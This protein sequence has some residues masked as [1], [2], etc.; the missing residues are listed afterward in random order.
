ME[1]RGKTRKQKTFHDSGRCENKSLC[2]FFFF[3][4]ARFANVDDRIWVIYKHNR[5]LFFEV[6]S[7]CALAPH[8]IIHILLRLAPRRKLLKA[9]AKCSFVQ[10]TLFFS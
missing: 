5:R 8:S 7:S 10:P 3:F 1:M 6:V 9:P 4:S 2:F